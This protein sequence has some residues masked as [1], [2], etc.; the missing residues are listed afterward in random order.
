MTRL[1]PYTPERLRAMGLNERQVKAVLYLKERGSV[2]NR[3]YRDL[4]GVLDETAR[5]DLQQIAQQGILL[6]QGRGRNTR[7][8]LPSA[9]K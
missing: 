2:T 5:L 3:E 4:T 8:L 7:Y 1:D 6:V 9:G